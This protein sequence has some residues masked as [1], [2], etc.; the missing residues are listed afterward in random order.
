MEINDPGM[1]AAA[2][3]AFAQAMNPVSR[4]GYLPRHSPRDL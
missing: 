4:T 3:S 2:F 1:N